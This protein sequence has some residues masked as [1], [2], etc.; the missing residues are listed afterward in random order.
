ME[1]EEKCV[2]CNV[3]PLKKRYQSR[4]NTSF[5]AHYKREGFEVDQ[6]DWWK[7]CD[8]CLHVYY[9]AVSKQNERPSFAPTAEVY[10]SSLSL[11]ISACS[12]PG[13]GRSPETF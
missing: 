3:S 12:F 5:H 9:N 4:K 10:L 2:K 8:S 7:I 1:S 13:E 11:P 6:A